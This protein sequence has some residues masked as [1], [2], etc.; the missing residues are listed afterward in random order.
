MPKELLDLIMIWCGV[1]VDDL[2]KEMEK[3]SLE[4][5]GKK[6]KFEKVEMLIRDE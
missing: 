3:R 6:K 5:E 1:T 4:V 2:D